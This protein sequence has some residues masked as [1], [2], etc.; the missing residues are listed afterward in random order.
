VLDRC[1]LPGVGAVVVVR[2]T[3][4]ASRRAP[5][6]ISA[7]TRAATSAP[8]LAAEENR[9]GRDRTV[10]GKV[11]A[12]GR[13]KKPARPTPYPDCGANTEGDIVFP[14][15]HDWAIDGVSL[16][17]GAMQLVVTAPCVSTLTPI[18]ATQ[19][20]YMKLSGRAYVCAFVRWSRSTEE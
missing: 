20:V 12:I 2:R 11:T 9:K 18:E 3:A 16:S 1:A 7:I 15:Q 6:S 5:A 17:V 8:S 19:D 10:A 4:A 13:G 14:W